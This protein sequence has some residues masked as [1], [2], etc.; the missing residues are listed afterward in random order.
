MGEVGLPLGLSVHQGDDGIGRW[1]EGVG[2]MG[3][4]LWPFA[5]HLSNQLCQELH[6]Q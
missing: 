3:S 4:S 1:S 2:V 5:F 6:Y